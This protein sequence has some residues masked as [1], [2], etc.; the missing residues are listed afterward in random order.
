MNKDDMGPMFK[1]IWNRMKA[2]LLAGNISAALNDVVSQNRDKYNAIFRQYDSSQIEQ[3]FT[4]NTD[5]TLDSVHDVAAECG[6][7][8]EESEGTY[9]YPVLYTIDENGIWKIREF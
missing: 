9:S 1:M 8:L 3:M 2:N 7:I 4:G 6:A 5:L